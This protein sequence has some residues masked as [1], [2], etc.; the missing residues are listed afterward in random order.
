MSSVPVPVATNNLN[1]YSTQNLEVPCEGPIA[2]PLRLDFTTQTAYSI[3]LDNVSALKRMS[4]IQAVFVDN[5]LG[6]AVLTVTNPVTGQSLVIPA[7]KQAYLNV[8]CPNAA[9]LMFTSQ[10]AI[11]IPV[12][13]LNFPV[14][15]LVW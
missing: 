5:S 4:M 13:L 11:V 1:F 9:E 7:N 6:T 8:L 12:H 14:I 10:S 2:L 15:N 3:N